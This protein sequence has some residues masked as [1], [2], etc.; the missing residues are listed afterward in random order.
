MASN[1]ILAS[2]A[3]SH[4]HEASIAEAPAAVVNCSWCSAPLTHS[5]SLISMLPATLSKTPNNVTPLSNEHPA[6]HGLE[7]CGKSL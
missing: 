1:C 7:M 2:L 4:T 6:W 5:L 3:N